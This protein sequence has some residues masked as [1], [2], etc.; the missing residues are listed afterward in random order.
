M[1]PSSRGERTWVAECQNLAGRLADRTAS[2]LASIVQGTQEGDVDMLVEK[3]GEM[4]PLLSSTLRLRQDFR[5][6]V[7][8]H[9]ALRYIEDLS[10]PGLGII[11]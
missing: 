2:C 6:E 3:L 11:R 8:R 10:W 5:E 1:T 7:Y 9:S 4:V